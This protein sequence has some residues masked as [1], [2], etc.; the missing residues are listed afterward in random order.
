VPSFH[1]LDLQINYA[2]NKAHSIVR[3]GASNLYNN[4]HIEAFGAAQIGAF[5]YASWTVSL[6][7]NDL[8]GK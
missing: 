4:E 2:I 6:G 3:V 1:T 5:Y 7:M 8:K